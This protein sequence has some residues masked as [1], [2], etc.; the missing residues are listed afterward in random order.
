MA[1]DFKARLRATTRVRFG[2]LRMLDSVG[3]ARPVL[4]RAANHTWRLARRWKRTTFRHYE[5]DERDV[6][7]AVY[8]KAGNNWMMQIGI[9]IA[10]RGAAQFDYIHDLVAWPHAPVPE[11]VV[12]MDSPVHAQSPTGLRVIETQLEHPA[13]P[14]STRA[15]YLVAIRD[16]RDTLVSTFHFVNGIVGGIVDVQFSLQSLFDFTVAGK[17]PICWAEHAASWWALRDR[18]N[19]MVATLADMKRDRLSHRNI[20]RC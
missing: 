10:H 7:V 3:L 5:P 13:T 16:P 8:P 20:M 2:V 9:Q 19:V 11:L 17:M 12:P 1:H 18:N 14:Y 4:A 6:F 15:H